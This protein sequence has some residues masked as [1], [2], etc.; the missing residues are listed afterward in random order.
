MREVDIIAPILK[1][2]IVEAETDLPKGTWCLHTKGKAQTNM[3]LRNL[4]TIAHKCPSTVLFITYKL[5]YGNQEYEMLPT[6][7]NITGCFF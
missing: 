4:T 6:L 2:R 3:Q 1:I 7:A 5:T